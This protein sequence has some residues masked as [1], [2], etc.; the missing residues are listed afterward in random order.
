MDTGAEQQRRP[1]GGEVRKDKKGCTWRGYT[2]G[3][4]RAE[5][6]GVGRLSLPAK[7]DKHR[8]HFYS[9]R[10]EHGLVGQREPDEEH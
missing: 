5:T 3:E 9:Q 4:D 2:Q 7:K 8:D 10:V 1:P 6:L